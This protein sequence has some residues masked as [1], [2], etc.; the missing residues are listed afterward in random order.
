MKLR[1]I[2]ALLLANMMLALPLC[3]LLATPAQAAIDLPKV[4]IVFGKNPSAIEATGTVIRGSTIYVSASNTLYYDLKGDNQEALNISSGDAVQR[5]FFKIEGN[6]NLMSVTPILRADLDSGR[7]NAAKGDYT[8]STNFKSFQYKGY[9]SR[10]GAMGAGTFELKDAGSDPLQWLPIQTNAS[11]QIKYDKNENNWSIINTAPDQ[12]T[13]FFTGATLQ[14]V[15]FIQEGNERQDETW[16]LTL[17]LGAASGFPAG[18]PKIFTFCPQQKNYVQD[19]PVTGQPVYDYS[20]QHGS[21]YSITYNY[22]PSNALLLKVMEPQEVLELVTANCAEYDLSKNQYIKLTGENDTLRYLTNKMQLTTRTEQYGEGVTL[23][24]EWVPMPGNETTDKDVVRIDYI[25]QSRSDAIINMSQEDVNGCLEVTSTY[26]TEN[27]RKDLENVVTTCPNGHTVTSVGDEDSRRHIPITIHGRGVPATIEQKEQRVGG[28]TT[29]QPLSGELPAVTKEMDVYRNSVPGYTVTEKPYQY[30]IKINMGQGNGLTRQMII[31]STTGDASAVDVVVKLGNEDIQ[32]TLGT[33]LNNPTN[34]PIS[35]VTFTA[36]KGVNPLLGLKFRFFVQG[37]NNSLREEV[38][39]ERTLSLR[40]SDTSPSTVA[41]LSALTII[42]PRTKDPVE[43]FAFL[44][45]TKEYNVQV[46]YSTEAVTIR[47]TPDEKAQIYMNFVIETM[48]RL[49]QW[50]RPSSTF[51]KDL[52]EVMTAGGNPGMW[53]VNWPSA[54]LA[55][56]DI[57]SQPNSNRDFS[58]TGGRGALNPARTIPLIAGEPTR[59]TIRVRAQDPNMVETYTLNIMRKEPDTDATLASLNLMGRDDVDYMTGFLFSQQD[60]TITVPYRIEE[61]R[62]L[63]DTTH[64][65]ALGEHINPD[66][67]P[68]TR[69]SSVGDWQ[70]IAYYEDYNTTDRKPTE[71]K[72]FVKSE[73]DLN[74]PRPNPDLDSGGGESQEDYTRTYTVKVKRAAPS[75]ISTLD[76]LTVN[77]R[78]GGAVEYTPAFH[79]E[80]VEG[81]YYELD[82]PYATEHLRITAKTTE[83]NASIRL[84]NDKGLNM[85]VAAN[86]ISDLVAIPRPASESDYYVINVEV[87]AEDMVTKTDYPI[88]VYRAPAATDNTL[89]SLV[90][91]DQNNGAIDYEFI[92]EVREYRITVPFEVQKVTFTPTANNPNVREIILDPPGRKINSGTTSQLMTLDETSTLFTLEVFPE[93]EL[94]PSGI[95][96]VTIVRS[97]ASTDALLFDLKVGNLD[98]K[99]LVPVFA[100]KTTSYRGTVAKDA[101]T[102]TVTPTASHPSAT[103]TVNGVRVASGQASGPI[104][105]MDVRQKIEVVVTAQDGRT[106]KTYTINLTNNNLVPKSDNADL[107]SLLVNYGSMTPRFKPSVSTYSVAVAEDTYSVELFPEPADSA[108]EVKVYLGTKEVGDRYGN[109]A[110]SLEDGQNEFVIEV[111]SSDEQNTKEYFVN[112]YRNDEEMQRDL[113]PIDPETIDYESS[114]VILVDITRYSRVPAEV[115]NRFMQYENKTI[116]FQGN[117]YSLQFESGDFKRLVPNTEIYDLGML[118]STPYLEEIEELIFQAGHSDNDDLEPVYL[119]FKHHGALPAPAQ[120]T[121]SL[122]GRYRNRSIYWHYYNDERDRIDYYGY[123]PTNSRGTFTTTIDHFS[124]YIITEDHR[125]YGSENKTLDNENLNTSIEVV[126]VNPS[127]G[128][129]EDKP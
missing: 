124:T 79:T 67:P 50:V 120:L 97:P 21:V 34:E 101:K 51:H 90:I 73:F 94:A 98:A 25:N 43:G 11:F 103:I 62:P 27:I 26:V 114:D 38:T 46:P 100:P 29:P 17:R 65:N 41:D 102:V 64:P 110:E 4:R 92:P 1:R 95:Y 52:Y 88:H 12:P 56:G 81:D 2:A 116:V 126:K 9:A 47:P 76:A 44:P 15:R 8:V 5:G 115:F 80:M 36:V 6:K 105:L 108:A 16:E 117:D 122:G 63:F 109:F 32:Y 14:S 10:V 49:A 77:D 87:T 106:T 58:I 28:E 112:V 42:D 75:K 83:P 127:T 66:L 60:Y 86:G 40:V 71:I 121:L 111:T 61:L 18:T 96:K 84:W 85:P 113:T 119:Y 78:N 31:E 104:N 37:N 19:D 35:E 39:A 22:L 69:I 20:T 72:I 125:I 53:V 3:R 68:Q 7:D 70:N 82:I 57:E 13:G 129:R 123:A 99:G 118:Y 24:W 93:D 23:N 128:A 59:V 45:E 107:E 33:P 48:N 89:S 74:K 55:D 54:G 30:T 91:A